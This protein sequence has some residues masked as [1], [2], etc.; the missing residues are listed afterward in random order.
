MLFKSSVVILFLANALTG[1]LRILAGILAAALLLNIFRNRKLKENFRRTRMFFLVYGV[2]CAIN[3]LMVREG[4]VAATL[5]FP[6]N[7]FVTREGLL[8]GASLF[9]RLVS[10][11]AL[12]WAAATASWFGGRRGKTLT[13]ITTVMEM[14]PEALTLIRRRMRLKAFMRYILSETKRKFSAE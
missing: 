2:A 11:V 4:K 12:S 8:R 7:W 9:L 14:L 1:D 5:P 13:L 3:V 10:C 6:G